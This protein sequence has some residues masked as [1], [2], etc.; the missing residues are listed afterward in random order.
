VRALRNLVPLFAMVLLVGAP[1]TGSAELVTLRGGGVVSVASYQV[2]G[3]AMLLVLRDGGTVRCP[4]STVARI[5]PDEVL[6]PVAVP[7]MPTPVEVSGAPAPYSELIDR[8]SAKYGL[9]RRLVHAVVQVES[10]YNPD[11]V[12]RRGAVGLMQLM[13]A[14][15]SRFSV[16]DSR[17]PASNLDGGIRYLKQ[18]LAQFSLPLALAAYNAGESAVLRFQGV[19]PYAETVAYVRQVLALALPAGI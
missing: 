7:L 18:L 2:D 1:A 16:A 19:P 10:G 8:L 15:A 9:D 13:P 17:D 14:T 3:D 11:A 12:S 6:R 4:L 5:D